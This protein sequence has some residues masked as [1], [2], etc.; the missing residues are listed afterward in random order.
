MCAL[1]AVR[2]SSGPLVSASLRAHRTDE[3]EKARRGADELELTAEDRKREAEEATHRAGA[4]VEETHA[5][6][7]AREQAEAAAADP[8]GTIQGSD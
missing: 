1:F 5:A 8:G 4:A 3:A 6:Q 7:G 2:T